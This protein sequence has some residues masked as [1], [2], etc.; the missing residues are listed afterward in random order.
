MLMY[1]REVV[2]QSQ[3]KYPKC[4]PSQSSA[5]IGLYLQMLRGQPITALDRES[6]GF[7]NIACL[8]IALILAHQRCCDIRLLFNR[9][10]L[11]VN[12]GSHTYLYIHDQFL[13]NVLPG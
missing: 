10:F 11:Y 8:L 1:H 6:W 9:E 2:Q 12:N 3:T 7:V 13:F 4:Q 5:V